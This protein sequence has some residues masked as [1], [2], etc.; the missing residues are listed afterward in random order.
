MQTVAVFADA[1]LLADPNELAQLRTAAAELGGGLSRLLGTNV[2]ARREGGASCSTASCPVLC[3]EVSRLP[4]APSSCCAAKAA[5]NGA[6][7]LAVTVGAVHQ[8]LGAEGFRIAS[9]DG[10]PM[11]AASCLGPPGRAVEHR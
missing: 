4:R 9:V 6:G 3:S 10:D 8:A 5:G 7:T 1:A 11:S 2:S